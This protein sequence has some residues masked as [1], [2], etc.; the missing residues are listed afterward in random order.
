MAISSTERL[1]LLDGQ[2]V[3]ELSNLFEKS[4]AYAPYILHPPE[5]L[6]PI[7]EA[8][9]DLPQTDVDKPKQVQGGHH[10]H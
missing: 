8:L 5:L 1:R 7:G 9:D 10:V 6:E 2:I 4:R 3:S